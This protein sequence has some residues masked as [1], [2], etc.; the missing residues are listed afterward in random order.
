MNKKPY[1][2][3]IIVVVIAGLSVFACKKTQRMPREITQY[4]MTVTADSRPEEIVRMLIAGLDNR[5]SELLGKL[6]AVQDAR[7]EME[8]ILRRY[9]RREKI[10][11]EDAI[12][13]TVAGWAATYSFYRP[14]DTGIVSET[15]EDDRATVIAAGRGKS[16]GEQRTMTIELIRED[17]WWKV[18]SGIR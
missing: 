6:V 10:T 4:G 16:T 18:M 9:R 3:I 8:K 2:N 12:K 13:L 11:D 1:V 5:D 7:D 17:G 14:G 15:I